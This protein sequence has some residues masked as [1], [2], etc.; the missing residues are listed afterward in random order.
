MNLTEA[1]IEIEAK[2]KV[3]KKEEFRG[4]TTLVIERA[5]IHDLSKFCKEQLGFTFLLDISSVDNFGEEPRFEAVYE[6]YAFERGEH[7]R[8]KFTISEDDLSVADGH[9]CVGDRGLA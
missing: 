7:L 5:A 2:F 9:R 3:L 8:L 6:L 4:E 1:V